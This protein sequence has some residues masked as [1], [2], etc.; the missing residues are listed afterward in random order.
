MASL[1]RISP[2][3][4]C[5]A[6]LLNLLAMPIGRALQTQDVQLPLWGG[7]CSANPS[8]PRVPA[9]DKLID[10]HA[11]ASLKISMQHGDCCCGQ[12][13]R[14]RC[15]RHTFGM[16]LDCSLSMP[17]C[18]IRCFHHRL[19]AGSGHV[20]TPAPLLLPDH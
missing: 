15:L 7:F 4:A 5:L 10:T 11:P 19:P 20:S 1:K 16:S 6:V 14:L 17:N 3:I 18:V 9:L 12:M 13:A 2:W 8:T